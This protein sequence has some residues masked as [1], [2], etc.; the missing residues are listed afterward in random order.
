LTAAF[1]PLAYA[2]DT[3]NLISPPQN[4]KIRLFFAPLV[5]AAA[6]A[7]FTA[8][9][10]H[11]CDI[12]AAKAN[13]MQMLLVEM[14]KKKD[15]QMM[16]EES[17]NRPSIL[18]IS[19]SEEEDNKQEEDNTA[20]DD[21]NN[22]NNNA[23]DAPLSVVVA[24]AKAMKFKK[25]M[26][27]RSQVGILKVVATNIDGRSR[28]ASVRRSE[29]GL[30]DN[31]CEVEAAASL[32]ASLAGSGYDNNNNN[33]NNNDNNNEST[34]EFPLSLRASEA[35]NSFTATGS[36]AGSLIALIMERR[37]SGSDFII[38]AGG[39]DGDDD[40]K[41]DD[42]PSFANRFEILAR[43]SSSCSSS[44]RSSISSEGG[45]NSCCDLDESSFYNRFAI[46]AR[47]LSSSSC[48]SCSSDAAPLSRIV[49]LDLR[50]WS[51][52]A[53]VS[54]TS[55]ADDADAA[56]SK[57]AITTTTPVDDNLFALE[58]VDVIYLPGDGGA[59]V[60]AARLAR[61]S[62]PVQVIVAQ[63]PLQQQEEADGRVE[64]RG[65]KVSGKVVVTLAR[66]AAATA[67]AVVVTAL[68]AMLAGGGG[69]AVVGAVASVCVCAADGWPERRKGGGGGI[70][71]EIC[72]DARAI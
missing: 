58:S 64:K 23:N 1:H 45:A 31:A 35:G 57:S 47:R 61:G 2:P 43:R 12:R 16:A 39:Y 52:D 34:G 37:W 28:R 70:R 14:L 41:D 20:G 38:G 71:N 50:R 17:A 56:A 4:N 54:I 30:R 3:Y 48:C 69:A 32:R 5:T 22:N 7:A 44:R 25:T 21:N 9:R 46:L 36:D 66:C 49:S 18:I 27:K 59:V 26:A 8:Q 55:A 68:P 65:N 10:A 19:A 13:G 6:V 29:L 72:A 11:A 60:F 67:M 51:S 53:I 15:L 40:E 24:A 63:S 33:N 62:D 42:A